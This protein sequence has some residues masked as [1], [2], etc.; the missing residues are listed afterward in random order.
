MHGPLGSDVAGFKAGGGERK[1]SV[2]AAL[3]AQVESGWASTDVCATGEEAGIRRAFVV[4]ARA[5][6]G[7]GQSAPLQSDV[8]ACP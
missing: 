1:L 8:A 4:T 2:A 5:A 3:P 6:N 7:A